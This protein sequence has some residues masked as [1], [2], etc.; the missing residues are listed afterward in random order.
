MVLIRRPPHLAPTLV[1]SFPSEHRST[2][3]GENAEIWRSEA[4]CQSVF[5]REHA[6]ALVTEASED[7]KNEGFGLHF[8]PFLCLNARV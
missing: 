6:R 7:A 3:H 4:S 2:A 5:R 1:I 8:T